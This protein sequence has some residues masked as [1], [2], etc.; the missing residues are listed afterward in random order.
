MLIG[1]ISQ[2]IS[3]SLNFSGN[4]LWGTGQVDIAVLAFPQSVSR[5]VGAG[6]FETAF[7][8]FPPSVSRSVGRVGLST[9]TSSSTSRETVWLGMSG[10]SSYFLTCAV[11]LF[12]WTPPG[13]LIIMLLPFLL[14][15]SYGSGANGV[16]N[17]F[18]SLV[19]VTLCHLEPDLNTL[20][21]PSCLHII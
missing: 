1:L 20:H 21:A 7:R 17:L 3:K 10:S 2:L 16:E 9:W 5:S 15:T 14:T 8:S 19:F 4:F 6:L 18:A 11:F 13:D 12:N